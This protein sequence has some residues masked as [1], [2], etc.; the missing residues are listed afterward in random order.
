MVT[1]ELLRPFE[2]DASQKC[3]RSSAGAAADTPGRF[4]KEIRVDA[5]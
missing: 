3:A 4:V 1:V 5:L 2:R